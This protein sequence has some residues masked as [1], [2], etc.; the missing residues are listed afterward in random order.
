MSIP[1]LETLATQKT[2]AAQLTRTL[3][4]SVISRFLRPAMLNDYSRKKFES[5][6]DIADVVASMQQYLGLAISSLKNLKCV[7]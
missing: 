5:Y 7:M 2:R 3:V 1:Q 4:I 6:T